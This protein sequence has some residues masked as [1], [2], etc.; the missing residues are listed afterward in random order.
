[1]F[2]AVLSMAAARFLYLALHLETK[3]YTVR[4]HAG[5]FFLP[6]FLERMLEEVEGT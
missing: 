3:Y 6:A 4:L 5:A 2:A 1:M